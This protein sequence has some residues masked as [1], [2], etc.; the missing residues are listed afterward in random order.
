MFLIRRK[1]LPSTDG[2][3]VRAAPPRW[4]VR[5]PRRPRRAIRRFNR[6]ARE[7][8]R[9]LSGN[10]DD[11]SVR[12]QG[13][14]DKFRVLPRPPRIPAD[15]PEA[16]VVEDPN[17]RVRYF[18]TYLRRPVYSFDINL[19][20][21]LNAEYESKPIWPVP[22]KYDTPTIAARTRKSLMEVHHTIDLAGKRVLEIGCG[23]GYHVWFL[24]HHFGSEAYGVDVAERVAWKALADDRTH[25]VWADITDKNPF[26]E[27]FFDRVISFAVWEHMTHPYRA[28][29]E[30]FRMLKPGGL[31][32][33]NA[34]LYRGPIASH[35]YREV[36]F[37][38]P[39]LLFSDEVIKD[40]YR[41]RGMRARGATWVNK[42]T[43]AQYERYFEQIGFK[44][45]MVKFIGR[46]FDRAFYERF[47]N[48]LN[49]YPIFD[50]SK[51]FFSAVLERPR[52]TWSSRRVQ[53]RRPASL[54]SAT[55]PADGAGA[56]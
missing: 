25:F 27:E 33:M 19:F 30:V 13:Y 54:E 40:F 2:S 15:W 35:L 55:K 22:P 38:W 24:G 46:P 39:H 10:R 29:E 28:L 50:L 43:W 31:V 44:V 9:G 3:G 23:T 36:K 56:G 37:P 18:P 21:R 6:A 52:P 17:D 53:K 26:S 42:L 8:M 48:V 16:P 47:D 41:R 7:L 5:L 20:E 51:D 34:N 14:P 12:V 32:W 4:R 11:T 49:R 1:S 45:K